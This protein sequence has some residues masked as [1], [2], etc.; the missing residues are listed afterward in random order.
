MRGDDLIGHIGRVGYRYAYYPGRDNTVDAILHEKELDRL[1]EAI[2]KTFR[3]TKNLSA[4]KRAPACDPVNSR[5]AR[6]TE[7]GAVRASA[8]SVR[9]AICP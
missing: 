3:W 9:S 7:P 8:R 1:K 4:R 2:E 6:P 5:G